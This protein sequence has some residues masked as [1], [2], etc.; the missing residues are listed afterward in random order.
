MACSIRNESKDGLVIKVINI[1][2][3]EYLFPYFCRWNCNP[4]NM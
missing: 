3:R 1:N 4:L 2:R